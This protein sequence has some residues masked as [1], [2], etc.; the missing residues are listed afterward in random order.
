MPRYEYRCNKCD[1]NTTINHLSTELETDCPRCNAKNS[2]TKVLTRFR[3]SQ[4]LSKKKAI[5][6]VTEDF[7]DDARKEL[8][9]QKQ[10]LDKNR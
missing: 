9:Q 6:Q 2:L 1:K 4:T 10:E 5:G 8:H 7:I 3:T